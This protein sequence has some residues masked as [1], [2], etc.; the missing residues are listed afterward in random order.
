MLLKSWSKALGAVAVAAVIYA[1]AANLHDIKRYVSM[2]M[3]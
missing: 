2:T 3:M 1:V